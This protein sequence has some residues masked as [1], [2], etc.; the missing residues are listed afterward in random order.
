MVWTICNNAYDA[1]VRICTHVRRVYRSMWVVYFISTRYR[2]VWWGIVI[3]YIQ[4][5]R[6]ATTTYI[7]I[8]GNFGSIYSNGSMRWLR[9]MVDTYTSDNKVSWVSLQGNKIGYRHDTSCIHNQ[10]LCLDDLSGVR[11]IGITAI[12]SFWEVEYGES[13]MI[14]MICTYD[15]WCAHSLQQS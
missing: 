11:G 7:F 3:M 12:H 4:Y 15:I 14:H 10:Q 6:Y 2:L 8:T 13:M 5:K 9:S 1:S